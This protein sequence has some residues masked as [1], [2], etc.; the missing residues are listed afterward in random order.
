MQMQSNRKTKRMNKSERNQLVTM[1]EPTEDIPD[2]EQSAPEDASLKISSFDLSTFGVQAAKGPR[3][4]RRRGSN[5]GAVPKIPLI[6]AG[7]RPTI[8]APFNFVHRRHVGRDDVPQVFLSAPPPTG[9]RPTAGQRPTPKRQAPGPPTTA[10]YRSDTPD[11]TTSMPDMPEIELHLD[12]GRPA[13]TSSFGS[14]AEGYDYN[15]DTDSDDDFF[16]FKD[17]SDEPT[18]ARV[19]ERVSFGS[20]AVVR[21]SPPL[22]GILRTSSAA[23]RSA[24]AHEARTACRRAIDAIGAATNSSGS[25]QDEDDEDPHGF[26]VHF[27]EMAPN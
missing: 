4:F 27:G 15:S 20:I 13:S 5:T 6:P 8:S 14:G 24:D 21:E 7:K 17:G 10:Y 26:R 16:G 23:Q 11:S 22:T 19:P 1:L 9:R 12:D 25:E 18:P 2:S 3:P